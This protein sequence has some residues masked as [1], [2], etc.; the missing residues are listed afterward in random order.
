MPAKSKKQQRLFGIIHAI[1][2]GELSPKKFSKNIR[3][4]AKSINPE[5]VTHFAETK[6]KN[7]PEKK[8]KDSE[9][10]AAFMDGFLYKCALFGVDAKA[11]LGY[12][13]QAPKQR[14]TADDVKAQESYMNQGLFKAQKRTRD[15]FKPIENVYDTASG[16]LGGTKFGKLRFNWN[17]AGVGSA[18]LTQR[19]K[20]ETVSKYLPQTQ[21]A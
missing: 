19:N 15:L 17:G 10:D 13:G 4:M 6:H 16:I 18:K 20:Q 2:K 21:R 14:F 3:H 12:Y 7:L 5:S 1:Q 9:K 8:E 11:L